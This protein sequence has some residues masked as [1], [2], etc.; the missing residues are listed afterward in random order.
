MTRFFM[1]LWGMVLGCMG[2]W[3]QTAYTLQGTVLDEQQE[4]LVGA[5]IVLQASQKGTSSDAQGKYSLGGLKAGTYV[6]QVSYLGY[7]NYTDTLRIQGSTTHL[8]QLQPRSKNLHEV[9][10]QDDYADQRKREESLNVE[11]VNEEYLKKNMGGSLM[12]SL[13]RLPGVSTL[14]IGSGQAKP[15]IRG[16]SFNRVVVVDNNIRHE[17][18]QWGADHGLEIDQ[19]AV[20]TVDV[21]KGPASLI[22]GSD[23]IGGVIDL[24]R[25]KIPGP[26]TL[27]GNIDLT[28]KSNNGY[29]GT[30]VFVYGRKKHLFAD[31]RITL[32]DYGDYRVPTD[33]VQ[34]YSYKAALYKNQMRNTAGDEHNLHLS[35][36]WVQ[37]RWLSRFYASRIA[38]KSGFFANAY[39]LEPRKVD[40]L[41]HDKSSRDIQYPYQTVQHLKV[42]NTTQYTADNW[43]LSMDLGFQ[44][45]LREERSSYTNHGYMPDV[46]PDTLPYASDL[47]RLFD[48]YV[49]SADVKASVQLREQ[50]TLKTGLSL[51]YQDN[52]INGHG[53]VIPA[54]TQGKAG[55]YLVLKE[56]LSGQSLLQAGLRYD[57][58]YIQTEAY[59][60]W[61]TSPVEENGDTT[62]QYLQRAAELNRRFHNFSWT[63]GYNYSPDN[64]LFKVN[65]G[66][67]F[68]MPIAKEL[69]ANGVNYHRFSYEVGD[70]DLSPEISYQLDAG[71]EYTTKHLAIG[72]TPFINYFTNY[73][74]LNPTADHD[75]LYGNGNQIFEYTESA[76]Y[77]W[78]GELHAH[79]D[80]MKNLELGFIG[81][82]VYAIQLSGEKEGYPLPF[83]P[84]ATALVN[85]KYQ[86]QKLGFLLNPYG[87]VD[88]KMAARQSHVVPPEEETPGYQVVH[89]SMGGSIQLKKQRIA[90]AL[91]V[92]NLF[93]TK[94]FNHT[95][96][97]R[98][99]NVPEAGR[100]FIVN[101][102]IPFAGSLKKTN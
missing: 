77:R 21:I 95:S 1:L 92:R 41:L 89:V 86:R 64:W 29:L 81:E 40:T 76:V 80:L 59:S 60:D 20:E 70:A 58:G 14:D 57:Q 62:Y 93:N 61:F 94:Y 37:G 27:G 67:S 4:P 5:Y 42:S 55:A 63:V 82:Y 12:N 49:Y 100:N 102:T 28:A 87:S 99:L 71:L 3:A 15:V 98:L 74:Y 88:L 35:L 26:N 90:L 13:E 97:Y 91:Q 53:F 43:K 9:V 83:S 31:A 73:I 34:M 48:K 23:A 45:N 66:K 19:Y 46:F 65:V 96:Y 2:L 69:A 79:Y 54:F 25:R 17:A 84:P 51:E 8:I 50:T 11:I 36:G 68:R 32:A 30:S 52:R 47:E 39:G 72:A 16:M 18:Q 22:Y 101:V 44:Q 85:L 24:K 56:E 75:R 6:L 78:G 10:V 33:Y 38:S 7:D